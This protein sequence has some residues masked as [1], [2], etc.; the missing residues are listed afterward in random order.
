[1]KTVSASFVAIWKKK[2]GAKGVIKVQYQR[3][4][5]N[6]A[7]YVYEAN[8]TDINDRDI[9]EIGSINWKLDTQ[10]LN[11]ILSSNITLRLN[12][13]GGEFMPV[14]NSPS[15]FAADNIASSGYEPYLTKF[16]VQFGYI[17]DNDTKEY[18]SLFTGFA[19]DYRFSG[20]DIKAEITVM[21]Y[22][23]LLQDAD[24]QNVST[25]VTNEA[26][27]PATGD[28]SNKTFS[29]TSVGVAK[30]TGVRVNSVAK[31]QGTDYS[32][33]NLGATTAAVIT[34]VVAPTSGH[35]VDWTGTKWSANQT[36]ED[37]IA[38]LCDESGVTDRTIQAAIFP[39]GTSSSVTIDSQANWQAGSVFTN[40]EADSSAGNLLRRWFLID[41][42]ADGNM[43]SNPSWT[44]SGSG[45]WSVTGG[46]GRITGAGDAY[47]VSNKRTGSW[48]ANIYPVS[49]ICEFQFMRYGGFHSGGSGTNMYS[50]Y[51]DGSTTALLRE[52]HISTPGPRS[53]TLLISVGRTPSASDIYRVTRASDG[54][55]KFYING[56]LQGTVNDTTFD[57]LS[58]SW[59][60]NLNGAGIAGAQQDFD[61]IYY[62]TLVIEASEAVS[63]ANPLIYESAEFDLLAIPTA[64]GTLDRTH[65]L[66]GGSIIYKTAGATSAGGSYESY[67]AIAGDG[68]IQSTLRRYLKIRIEITPA[69]FTGVFTGP[70]VDRIIANFQT[71]QIF[72]A[73]A[74]FSGKTCYSA[75]QLLAR[76]CDYEWGFTGTGS[77]F[78]RSKTPTSSDPAVDINQENAIVSLSEWSPGYS[79]VYNSGQVRYGAYYGS[80]DSSSLP[81]TSPTS[82]QKFNDKIKSEDYTDFL[83]ANDGNLA[84]ARARIIHDNNYLPKKRM[85][86]T[87]R[88]IPHLD[89]SDI[90]RVSYFDRPRDK[91][92][93]WGDDLQTWSD[94]G[95]GGMGVALAADLDM[96]VVG[97]NFIFPPGNSQDMPK[98][99]LELMEVL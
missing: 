14:A 48:Q 85:R 84:N 49:G 74:N 88:I 6:G 28:G 54:E 97:I 2:Y 67:V 82:A 43:T 10:T 60:I 53:Y 34:M 24:A 64:W 93:M 87:T 79:G 8:W 52:D 86:L 22:E 41:D 89:L 69:Q 47:I 33:S 96:K 18:I 68:T 21:G 59:H 95:Y 17:L 25:A 75:I 35:A 26:T 42:F 55:M 63:S 20:H 16:R 57:A 98:C 3:R 31:T 78:F 80:Y 19:V 40:T 37:L 29:T 62:S 61:D 5:W 12:N 91:D 39:G 51:V 73:V 94:S 71:S 32:I 13:Y 76:M 72:I 11:E 70:S 56:S 36:V 9:P 83:L 77:F 4:Y 58:N 81:E 30:I 90:I 66:N 45:T 23:Q 7:A 46:K 15:I 44:T 50:V 99:D 27:S 1:M 92:P 38:D 65:T